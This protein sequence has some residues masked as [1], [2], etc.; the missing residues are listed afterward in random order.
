MTDNRELDF[1]IAIIGPTRVGKTSLIASI[2]KDS[3]RLLDGTPLNIRPRGLAT[4]RRIA[5]HSKELEGSIRA[6]EFKPGAVRGTEEHFTFEL[7]LDPGVATVGINLNVLD[8]P[9]GWLDADRRPPERAA[10]W[11]YCKDWM[12]KST[13]LLVPVESA[14]LMEAAAAK[15]RKAA[16]SILTTYEVEEVAR[17]WAKARHLR[18][19][20]PAL[21]ML[22][23]VKCES[24]FADNGGRRD[25]SIDLYKAV[26]DMYEG[27]IRAV[28][29][30]HP[31]VKIIYSPVD[32]IGCVEIVESCWEDDARAPGGC[33]FTAEYRVRAPGRQTV[34]GADTIL[35]SICRHLIESSQRAEKIKA[36]EMN[37]EAMH[38]RDLANKDEGFLR[39][40][41]I[42]LSGER[43]NRVKDAD[44]KEKDATTQ[45]KVVENLLELIAN[46]AG[47][48]LGPRVRSIT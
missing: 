8:Y 30:N 25:L 38:A 35:I 1:K 15:H 6:G 20:E 17:D 13:V 22:C 26:L 4:E 12:T 39:N 10:E 7:H 5:Q 46:L 40:I 29:G 31:N 11:Q 37:A 45:K 24:Y 27:T 34:K 28:Q 44:G 47:R 14:V 16:P 42:W 48:H 33:H 41:L 3:H 2:L 32:T 43:G 23:P 9:G 19:D 36:K 18:P 21:L